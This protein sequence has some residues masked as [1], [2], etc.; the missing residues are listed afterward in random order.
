MSGRAQGP[1]K[2]LRRFVRRGMLVG[3]RAGYAVS[4]RAGVSAAE[5]GLTV[6]LLHN[7]FPDDVRRLARYID[8]QRDLFT[9]FDKGVRSVQDGTL[10]RPTLALSFDDGFRSN[11]RAAAMLD[12]RGISAIF[13]V[14]TDV[15]GTGKA[16][17]DAFFRRPQ[18][19]GVMSWADLET[20]RDRGHLVGSHCRQHLPLVSFSEA[21]A[22]DQLKGS[23]EALRER[24]GPTHHFAWPFGGLSHAP[25]TKV[26]RWSA[27]IGVV[28]A[29]GIRGR[30]L[31]HRL[32][33]AGFLRR[34]AVDPRWIATDLDVFGVRDLKRLSQTSSKR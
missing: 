17:S 21:A 1:L 6:L 30:N 22:E 31:S 5:P 27:E 13:Y 19:E 16:A 9:S 2:K 8:G 11:M 24:L 23:V 25:V 12:E 32:E 4:G 15:I 3:T 14:P 20:L 29:S 34:D 26:V 7:T 18:A 33:L 10:D 28:P